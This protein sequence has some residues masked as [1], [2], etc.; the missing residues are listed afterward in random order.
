M[1]T[2]LLSAWA[3]LCLL[4]AA[5]LDA[6]LILHYKLDEGS[7]TTAADTGDG[8][9]ANA[10][11]FGT[12]A[13]WDASNPNGTGPSLSVNRNSGSSYLDG[14]HIEKLEGLGNFTLT[15]WIK[16]SDI[17][18]GDRLFS[19]WDGGTGGFFDLRANTGS[20]ANSLN[21]SFQFSNGTQT[22]SANATVGID[23]TQWVFIAIVYNGSTTRFYLGDATAP[24]ATLGSVVNVTGIS[25]INANSGEFRLGSTAA[26][27]TVRTPVGNFSDFRLYDEALT[28]ND[29]NLIRT[30]AIPE[31][32]A[33]AYTS[34]VGV[35]LLGALAKTTGSHRR[36]RLKDFR[37]L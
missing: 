3:A 36:A 10:A 13:S 35:C 23:A 18:S 33:V 32:N 1:K 8:T 5:P 28:A 20:S 19:T 17:K 6:A 9:P 12:G 37:A 24:V 34:L 14:G 22:N 31:P 30:Q 26:T 15:T 7:G 2:P 4:C 16:F 11:F 25:N 21:L 27:T 29:L